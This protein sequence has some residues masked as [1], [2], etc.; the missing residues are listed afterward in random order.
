MEKGRDGNFAIV[1]CWHRLLC[2]SLSL[3][4]CFHRWLSTVIHPADAPSRQRE[5]TRT[6]EAYAAGHDA[7]LRESLPAFAS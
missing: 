7:S 5:S 2:L 4:S 3:G 6:G 1:L